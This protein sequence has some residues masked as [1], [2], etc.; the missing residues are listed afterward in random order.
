[1]QKLDYRK[2]QTR[3]LAERQVLEWN[4]EARGPNPEGRKKAESH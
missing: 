4:A 3:L 1:V 2:L